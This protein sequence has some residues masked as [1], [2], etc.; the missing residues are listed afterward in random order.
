MSTFL[1]LHMNITI[2]K[3]FLLKDHLFRERV[4]A[5]VVGCPRPDA[6]FDGSLL[7]DQLLSVGEEPVLGPSP[8]SAVVQRDQRDDDDSYCDHGEDR[9]NNDSNQ[10]A[11]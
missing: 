7:T 8:A 2:I 5:A 9:Q 10:V 11:F 4:L 1:A 3:I 6:R